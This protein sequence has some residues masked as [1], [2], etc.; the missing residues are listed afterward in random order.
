MFDIR[1]DRPPAGGRPSWQRL[2][3]VRLTHTPTGAMAH[4]DL[5]RSPK[6]CHDIAMGLLRA[7]VAAIRAGLPTPDQIGRVRSY[8]L[9]PP[10][11]ITPFIR[12]DRTG[13]TTDDPLAVLDGGLDRLW[14]A[15]AK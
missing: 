5:H 8:H 14:A 12:D 2:T 1:R 3:A 4:C 15:R 6:Q 9:D 7:R 11:G 13:A 10:L